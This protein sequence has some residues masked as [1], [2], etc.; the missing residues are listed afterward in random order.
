MSEMRSAKEILSVANSY[1]D[2]GELIADL[3]LSIVGLITSLTMLGHG[4]AAP[5]LL[6]DGV[7][8]IFYKQS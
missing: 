5:S 6:K 1:K 7:R 2:K 3:I 8:K 4:G